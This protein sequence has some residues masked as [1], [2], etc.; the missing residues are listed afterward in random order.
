MNSFNTLHMCWVGHSRVG[1]YAYM[2]D[3]ANTYIHISREFL[4]GIFHCF[5][6][7][8]SDIYNDVN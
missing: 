4:Y 7:D 5:E 1:K 3:R 8:F 6:E 2:P